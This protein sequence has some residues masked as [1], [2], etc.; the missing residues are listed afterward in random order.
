MSIP[1]NNWPDEGLKLN[2]FT[3]THHTL[4]QYINWLLIYR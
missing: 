2:W 3:A 4:E 1:N